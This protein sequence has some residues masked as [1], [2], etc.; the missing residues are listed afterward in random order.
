[1]TTLASVVLFVA[2][3]QRSM[4]FYEAVG[5]PVEPERH[6]EGPVHA[7]AELGEVHVAIYTGE[8]AGQAPGRRAC[9]ST[10]VGFYVDDLD[11]VRR[12]LVELG[13]P[14]LTEHEAMPWGCRIVAEDPDGRAVEIN[15]QSCPAHP[16]R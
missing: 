3:A 6:D 1:M 2:D 5:V 8:G 7:A 11:E 4:L 10:F 12:R 13:A 15:A 14:I 9:G 16:G